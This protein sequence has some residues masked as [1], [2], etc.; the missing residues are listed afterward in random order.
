MKLKW[1]NGSEGFVK[2]YIGEL[3]NKILFKIYE[4]DDGKCLLDSFGLQRVFPKLNQAKRAARNIA[5]KFYQ[6]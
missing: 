1:H 6:D 2:E 5:Q 4:F 3:S